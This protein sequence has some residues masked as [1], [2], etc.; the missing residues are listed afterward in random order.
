[1]FKAAMFLE[2]QIDIV[3]YIIVINPVNCYQ[4]TPCERQGETGDLQL[5]HSIGHEA[6]LS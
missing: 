5:A 4:P 1:M 2:N 6:H 3:V